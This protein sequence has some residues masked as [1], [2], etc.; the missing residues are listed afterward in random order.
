MTPPLSW[1]FALLSFFGYISCMLARIFLI[2]AFI[3]LIL[4]SL[5]S[6]FF[7]HY[8]GTMISHPWIF[9]LGSILLGLIGI[10]LR[11]L[12]AS[13]AERAAGQKQSRL[14]ADLKANGEKILVDL[15]ACEIRANHYTDTIEIQHVHR[16]SDII[17]EDVQQSVFIFQHENTRKG[18]IEKFVSPVISKDKIT[19][20]F[21]FDRQRQTTLYVNKV[22][23]SHYYF[24]LNFLADS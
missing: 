24:D 20:S 16:P 14:I 22:N 5:I 21:Y 15:T 2:A 13:T 1:M 9:Y 6:L 12:A 11:V 7:R 3:L 19:L 23:R 10:F 17:A 18:T 8:N 4:S